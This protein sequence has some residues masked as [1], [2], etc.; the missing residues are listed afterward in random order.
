MVAPDVKFFFDV[1]CKLVTMRKLSSDKLF[2]TFGEIET[3]VYA[4]GGQLLGY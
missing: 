2:V 3:T 4:I 1:L